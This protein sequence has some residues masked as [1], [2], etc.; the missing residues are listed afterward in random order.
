MNSNFSLD[1]NSSSPQIILPRSRSYPFKGELQV[2]TLLVLT[3][4]G[5]CFLAIG[6]RYAFADCTDEDDLESGACRTSP[7]CSHQ[8]NPF[9]LPPFGQLRLPLPSS[10][11]S[12]QKPAPPLQASH[13]SSPFINPTWLGLLGFLICCDSLLIYKDARKLPIYGNRGLVRKRGCS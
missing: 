1:I 8:C 4:W 7:D 6:S 3:A 10:V 9:S 5:I 12:W 2:K 11:A 13:H